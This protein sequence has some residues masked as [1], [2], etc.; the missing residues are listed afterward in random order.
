MNNI[1]GIEK[2]IFSELP[3]LNTILVEG[4]TGTLKTTFVLECI[5]SCLLKNEEKVCLF[6]S[7]KE[8]K[9]YFLRKSV[10]KDLIEQRRFHVLDYEN[11]MD[12]LSSYGI[13]RNIFDGISS[14]ASDFKREYNN[15][16]SI[17]AMDP[18][19]ALEHI[20]NKDNNNLRRIL[21]HFF[22]RLRDLET[23]NWIIMESVQ[24]AL[25]SCATLPYHFLADGIVSLGMLETADDVIRYMEIIKMRGAEHS[26]KKFQI[27]CKKNELKILGTIY[28]S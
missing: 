14:I 16:F 9:N 21:F 28:E 11:L 19:N 4:D 8:E 25:D 17:F 6:I 7:L 10:I 22:S 18:I 13:R 26:L 23:R 5:K 27:E 3:D 24:D 2:V 1:Q 12:K 15:R 20:I